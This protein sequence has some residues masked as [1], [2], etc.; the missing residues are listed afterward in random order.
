MFDEELPK[1]KQPQPFPR[2][3][4]GLSVSQMKEYRVGLL[5]EIATIDKEIESRGGLKNAAEDLFK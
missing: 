3:L 4:D 2:K 5:V 1:T